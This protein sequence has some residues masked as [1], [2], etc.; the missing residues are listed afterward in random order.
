MIRFEFITFLLCLC[1]VTFGYTQQQINLRIDSIENISIQEVFKAFE[2]QYGSISIDSFAQILK[3]QTPFILQKVDDYSFILILDAEIIDICGLVIDAVSSFGL[4]QANIIKDN[5]V[6][7]LTD[8]K[9]A[10]RLRLNPRDSIE[11]SYLGY[12][13]ITIKADNN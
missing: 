3:E 8:E 9:G 13:T 1:S 4:A 10:F 6:I 2:D 7:S 11:I 5:N 12:K